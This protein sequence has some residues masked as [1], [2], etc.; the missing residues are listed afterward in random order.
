MENPTIKFVTTKGDMIVELYEDKVPNTVANIISLAESGY[1][2]DMSFH[3]ILKDFMAQ[4]GCPNTKTGETGSPGTG[5]PG[6]NIAEEFH[7]ELK[8]NE[9]GILS[10]A[11]TSAPNSTGSQFFILFKDAAFLDNGYSVFGKVIEGLEVIDALEE[12][13]S[14]RDGM[15]PTET[16]RFSIEVVSK[17]DTDYTVTKA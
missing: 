13:S 16:I 2:T 5:G 7:P 12:A 17:N 3:R 10:M 6:Y 15:P 14:P 8:H 11:K 9:R 4:G 1:Y